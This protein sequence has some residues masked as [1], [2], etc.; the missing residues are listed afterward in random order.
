MRDLAFGQSHRPGP[1]RRLLNTPVAVDS[2]L[3][4]LTVPTD[5]ES[6]RNVGQIYRNRHIPVHPAAACTASVDIRFLPLHGNRTR[7]ILTSIHRKST[8]RFRSVDPNW[9]SSGA[10]SDISILTL[11][12]V[13]PAI[14]P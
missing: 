11:S 12:T 7:I 4:L 3:Q 1:F 2:T 14:P 9:M 10:G 13:V 6:S 5:P 8:Q